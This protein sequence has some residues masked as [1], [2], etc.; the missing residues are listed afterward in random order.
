MKRI[1]V[2]DDEERITRLLKLSLERTGKFIVTTENKGANAI[3][4]ARAFKPDLILL[5]IMMPDM[6]GEYVAGKIKEDEELNDIIIVFLSG[7]L[8]KNETGN[9]GKKI[10]RFMF[11]AKPVRDDD[12]INCIENQIQTTVHVKNRRTQSGH[13]AQ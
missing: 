5:D 9:T 1:L 7:L 8:T 2:V 4:A 6:A 10:G 13:C 3:N 11:L 12:L